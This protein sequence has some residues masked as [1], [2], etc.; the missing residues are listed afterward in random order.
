VTPAPPPRR[1]GFPR[2]RPVFF[3]AGGCY[4]VASGL[5]FWLHQP[6]GW[7]YLVCA[8]MF[9]AVGWLAGSGPKP[10]AEVPP[11]PDAAPKE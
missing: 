11:D 6:E 2:A 8:G 5:K 10:S 9:L 1:R 7:L 3:L 4:V